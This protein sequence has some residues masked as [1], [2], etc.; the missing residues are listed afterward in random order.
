MFFTGKLQQQVDALKVD[1]ERLTA[2]NLMLMN[3]NQELNQR[4]FDSQSNAQSAE[5]ISQREICAA[6]VQGGDL[7][8]NVRTT[9][10]KAAQNLRDEKHNLLDSLG[11]FDE[12]RQAVEVILDRVQVI[13]RRAQ[14]GNDNVKSLLAVSDE[15]EKFVGVIRDIS[16]Q[17]NL[18]A[19]NA[20]IEAARAG[21]SG[22][23][24][25]VVADEVRN[26]ARKASEA[27]D[28]I[29]TL[30][31]Q[32]S[33]QTHV[34]SEDIGEVDTLSTEVVSSAEQIK[35]GVHQ[36]VDLSNRMNAVISGSA[37]DTFIET[38]K[39][40]HIN[41]KNAVYEAIIGNKLEHFTDL[42]DHTACRL[43][44]WY[45]TGEGHE[46]YRHLQ[47]FKQLDAPHERVHSSGRAAVD[48]A[49]DGDLQRAAKYLSAMEQA[50]LEVGRLL[51]NLNTE[52][53][54]V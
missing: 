47:S 9:L 35:A 39:L 41:W 33:D 19:L 29:A 21:E 8:A 46:K 53:Q 36:V 44:N 6:W 4:I 42:A 7:V 15:I 14:S 1:V 16:D 54:A 5:E 32:I 24:F 31:G 26:L 22:R 37:A 45:Y 18:L 12:T 11:I 52:L 51:D 50:S 3:E 43:G 17:T 34:A 27:S 13:Q 20:A 49:R 30:V 40:D 2:E 23:G 38:V 10:A 28:E 48:A 25:A